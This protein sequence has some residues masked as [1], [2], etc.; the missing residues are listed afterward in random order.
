MRYLGFD[1]K[2]GLQELRLREQKSHLLLPWP[3]CKKEL[4]EFLRE[5]RFYTIWIP[6]FAEKASTLY[7]MLKKPTTGRQIDFGTESDCSGAP[8]YS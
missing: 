4:R 2:Q 5:A 8:C 3:D 7:E 1:L 6:R